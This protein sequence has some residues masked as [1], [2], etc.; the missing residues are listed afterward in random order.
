MLLFEHP[1]LSANYLQKCMR[2]CGQKR[3]RRF[4][5]TKPVAYS[6]KYAVQCHR[7]IQADERSLLKCFRGKNVQNREK[8]KQKG[9]VCTA[10]FSHNGNILKTSTFFDHV[11][12]GAVAVTVPKA[13][14]GSDLSMSPVALL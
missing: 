11:L 9:I 4:L 12:S 13:P 7:N 1:I 3:T 8:N 6:T 14:T 2:L 5:R 10:I